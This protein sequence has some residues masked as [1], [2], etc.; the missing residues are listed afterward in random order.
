PLEQ[1][2]PDDRAEGRR[3]ALSRKIE[4]RL[5]LQAYGYAQ[6]ILHHHAAR[7][8]VETTMDRPHISD[9]KT[10]VEVVKLMES[11][12]ALEV[13]GSADFPAI[14]RLDIKTHTRNHGLGD[15][16]IEILHAP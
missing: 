15:S 7:A 11:F 1:R 14:I 3:A 16:E 12:A 4:E 6:R 10:T 2:H 9:E 8:I 5:L 13:E